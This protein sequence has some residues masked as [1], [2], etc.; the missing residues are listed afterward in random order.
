VTTWRN[1]MIT[2]NE[3]LEQTL[4]TEMETED[5]KGANANEM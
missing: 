1:T 2:M 5:E 3:W 4:R